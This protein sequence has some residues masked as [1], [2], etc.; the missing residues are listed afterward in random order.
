MAKNNKQKMQEKY[1]EYQMIE[2]Q[3]QLAHK[4]VEQI[5]TQTLD[6][7]SVISYLDDI[8]KTEEGTEILVPVASGVFLKAEIKDNKEMIVNVGSDTAVKKTISEV[9]DMLA[10]Q[11]KELKNFE[12]ELASQMQKLALKSAEL[13]KDIEK[14]SGE[15]KE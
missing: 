8:S 3:V 6:L 1:M 14:L 11:E 9:K 4:Q 7:K 12:V 15:S 13:E 2:Q 5:E 10:R